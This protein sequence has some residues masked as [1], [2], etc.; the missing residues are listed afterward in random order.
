MWLYVPTP[1]DRAPS[2]PAAA[3]STSDLKWQSEMLAR[4]L[5]WRG[6]PSRAPIWLQRCKRVSWLKRLY[7]AMPEPSMAER[8]VARLI[9][10]LVESPASLTQLPASDSAKMTNAISGQPS[11]AFLSSPGRGVV[12]S[13]TSRECLPR[14]TAKRPALSGSVETYKDWVSSLRADYSAR[15]KSARATKDNGSSFSQWPTAKA[16]TGGANS[17]RDQRP[18]TGGPE[19]QEAAE[20]WPTATARDWKD[21]GNLEN[22]PE[23]GLLGRVAA[24][25][26]TPQARD[27]MPPHTLERVAAMKALGHGMRN[28]ND[29]AIMWSTPRIVAGSYTRDQGQVGAERLTLEGEAKQWQT[30]SVADTTGGRMTRSGNRNNELLLKG[31]AASFPQDQTTAMA[32]GGNSA[33][34]ALA[35]YRRYRATTDSELRFERLWM[36][37]QSIRTRGKGWTRTEPVPFV[38]P[39]FRRQL[40]P[41]F[42]E[43]L[44]G[45]QRHWTMLSHGSAPT[46]CA[47]SET[48]SSRYRQ[49]MQSALSQLGSP[50][51]AQPVQR[52]LFA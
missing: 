1:S 52:S 9:A 47:C 42:V 39:A 27:Q 26:A 44:M 49:L 12:L 33:T 22:V 34:M 48:A 38:R 41:I 10:S 51:K 45:W 15:R 19:L 17:K 46:D 13:K 20:N 40:N 31:Q 16:M 21:T 11:D 7:G 2:A 30:P 25:W 32:G 37:R 14:P 4:H 8:G 6:K 24:N 35:A 18:G 43:W 50:P 23:N 3:V 36:L 28:L 5:W 29:E